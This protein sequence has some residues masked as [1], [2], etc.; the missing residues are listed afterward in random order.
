MKPAD[1]HNQI[2]DARDEAEEN[3]TK[4]ATKSTGAPQ[5]NEQQNRQQQQ[6]PTTNKIFVVSKLKVLLID[7]YMHVYVRKD[8]LKGG[9][10]W[11]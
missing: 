9:R 6:K 4:P 3:L 8:Q 7:T 2:Q 5:A 10:E 1:Q 11:I